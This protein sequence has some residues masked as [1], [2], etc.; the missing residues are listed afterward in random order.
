MVLMK[1]FP[2]NFGNATKHF[3]VVTCCEECSPINMHD[4]PMGGGGGGGLV[5]SRD[6]QNTVKPVYNGHAI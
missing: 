2:R 4:T 6:K 5:A 1:H 3:R